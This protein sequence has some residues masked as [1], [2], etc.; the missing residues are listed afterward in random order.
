MS[1]I[2]KSLYKGGVRGVLN[3]DDVLKSKFNDSRHESIF[4]K[5]ELLYMGSI[6]TLN[7]VPE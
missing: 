2:K 3:H 4:R 1:Y 5:I 7:M 6:V